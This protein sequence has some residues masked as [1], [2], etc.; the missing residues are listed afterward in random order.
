MNK[1]TGDFIREKRRLLGLSQE[2]LAEKVGVSRETVGSW[3]NAKCKEMKEENY[4]KLAQVFGVRAYEIRAGKEMPELPE[5]DR[6]RLD[7]A[8]KEL[9]E[10]RE[11]TDR[12]E[13]TGLVSAEI[14]FY[15]Y[16]LAMSA[17]AVGWMA[18]FPDSRILPFICYPL[19]VFGFL[20]MFFGKRVI[21]EL[22][23]KRSRRNSEADGDK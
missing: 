15:A 17:F 6:R 2:D 4:E 3:E 11:Q 12:A 10:V 19:L 1:E 5:D 13:D 18:N 7:R 16:G 20:F 14:G 22:R 9:C 8:F 21:N 23:R